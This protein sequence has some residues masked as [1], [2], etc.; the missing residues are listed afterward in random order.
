MLHLAGRDRFVGHGGQLVRL[1]FDV[2]DGTIELPPDVHHSEG[3]LESEKKEKYQG[4]VTEQQSS[5]H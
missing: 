4:Q 2:G 1:V 5:D 3:K